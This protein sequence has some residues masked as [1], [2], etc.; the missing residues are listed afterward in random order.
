MSSK[1][2]PIYNEAAIDE[3]QE[4]AQQYDPV[5]SSKQPPPVTVTVNTS[6]NVEFETSMSEEQGSAQQLAP[7]TVSEEQSQATVI[8]NPSAKVEDEQQKLK[9]ADKSEDKD[10]TSGNVADKAD[11]DRKLSYI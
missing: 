6:T 10:K 5:T 7:V 11:D 9:S 4:G 1:F 2:S 3:E 8:A